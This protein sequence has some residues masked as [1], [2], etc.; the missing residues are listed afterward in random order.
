MVRLAE[1]VGAPVASD[2]IHLC[3]PSNHP[4]YAGRS[5][6]PYIQEADVILVLDQEFPTSQP[7]TNLAQ[8]PE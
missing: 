7:R 5:S 6:H 2:P 3:F 8:K 1:A 4:M